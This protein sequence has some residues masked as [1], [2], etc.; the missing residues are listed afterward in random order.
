MTRITLNESEVAKIIQATKA[1]MQDICWEKNPNESWFKSEVEVKNKL[2]LNLKMHLNANSRYYGLYSF[3][4]I[5]NN[6]FRIAG[7]DVNGSHKNKHT[8]SNNW[9]G[10]THKHKWTDRC[11][12]GW[13]YTPDD[14][15][16]KS[17]GSAFISFCKECEID[18]KGKF[19]I[20]PPKQ[21][22]LM[23]LNNDLR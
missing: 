22:S 3:T 17:M 1:I 16:V 15:D 10:E 18:F 21:I 23:R 6:A 11:R 13:A 2:R 9:K 5:L 14:I 20:L 7:L 8:D 19:N 4:L 12:D